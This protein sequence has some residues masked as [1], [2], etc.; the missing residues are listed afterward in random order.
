M[1][2]ILAG[3]CVGFLKY[4]FHPAKI[5]MGDTGSNFLGLFFAMGCIN[6]MTGAATTVAV[7]VPL[8]AVGVPIFDVFLATWRRLIRRLGSGQ[9][10]SGV[11]SADLDHLHHRIF[12]HNHDQRKTAV[13]LYL[14][15]C[16][17]AFAGVAVMVGSQLSAAFGYVIVLLVIVLA[18]H[19]FATVEMNASAKMVLKG[20]HKPH[21]NFIFIITHPLYDLCCV[22][23]AYILT[24]LLMKTSP[25][26]AWM[27]SFPYMMVFY[28]TLL[29]SGIYKIY[30]FRTG[31][32][33][34]RLL[35][36]TL[37]LA[38]LLAIFANR[39]CGGA[40][41]WTMERG[42]LFL[43]LA[44]CAIVGERLMIRYV[45][46][47]MLRQIF[48]RRRVEADDLDN[49][50]IFGGG[51]GC[52]TF[53]SSTAYTYRD[54]FS[55]LGIVDDDRSLHG[56]RLYGY[57]VLGGRG[58]LEKLYARR[59]FQRMIVTSYRISDETVNELVEFAARHNIKIL[60]FR[61]DTVDIGKK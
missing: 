46:G 4:N 23:A 19:K 16:V 12:A 55:V 32:R 54:I 8:M 24:N 58:D 11:M 48:V 20:L 61:S 33:D 2:L 22:F 51:Q 25:L 45:E 28:V 5:F 31:L 29:L 26:H 59:P 44:S 17:L 40:E 41:R 57:K 30:W 47:F 37:F 3:S 7:F 42:V 27:A 36:E 38:S 6:S 50:V 14:F 9:K 60:R 15:A 21:R 49:V 53:L 18:V 10:T 39:V 43:M 52:R 13:V 35:V 34:Y 1:Y 56:M